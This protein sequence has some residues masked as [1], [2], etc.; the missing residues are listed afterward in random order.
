Y[1]VVA[2]EFGWDDFKNIDVKGKT[3]VVLINDPPVVD[4][5][6]GQLDEKMF[7]GKRMTY[8]GR[9]TYKYDIAAEKG[10]IACLIVHETA[11]AAYPFAVL[12][13]SRSR[14]NFEIQ[15]PDN[16]AS[17]VAMEGWLTHDAAKRLFAATGH[18]YDLLKQTAARR[19]FRPVALGA[20]ASFVI[21]SEIR[22]VQ[23]KNVVAKITGID[24]KL[25]NEYVVYSAHWDHLGR[26][27]RLQGD[28]IYN[29]AADNAAGTA[30]LL[31]I[32]QAFKALPAAEQ[33]KRSILF[34]SVTAEEKG[35]LGARYYVQQPLY[36]LKKTLANINMDGANQFSATSDMVAIGNGASS[37]DDIGVA[38]A[39]SQGR[40]MLP[41]KHPEHGSYYRSDHFEFAKV[42]V[43]AYYPKAG[44]QFIGKPADF[45]E[46]LIQDYL[47]NDY[48][49]VTDEVRPEWTFEGAEQDTEFLM[50]VGLIPIAAS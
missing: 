42:G 24:P 1:G 29:G 10:A 37:I 9:W 26:D 30:V 7:G 27:S 20:K 33:P 41:E 49:K 5:A 46:K 14:E 47:A 8:Y 21:T 50:K 4:S 17:H 36:P 25:K 43:P 38:V 22:N 15:T 44:T 40:T 34:L 12:I 39:Q 13:G 45:G 28:Q 6:T 23:S 35:L 18:D 48:H 19:D 32:A 16:N 3:V 2:P 11:P 31:E